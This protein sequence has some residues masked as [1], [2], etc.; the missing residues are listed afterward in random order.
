MN[1]R[2]DDDPRD[3]EA[4]KV[5]HETFLDDFVHSTESLV[6]DSKRWAVQIN[7]SARASAKPSR[8]SLIKQKFTM[9]MKWNLQA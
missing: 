6:I 4:R 2:V 7:V 8:I 3:Q 5:R 9:Q 1:R